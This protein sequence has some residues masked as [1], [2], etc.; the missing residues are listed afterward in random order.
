VLAY[1]KV[2][3]L[4]FVVEVTKLIEAVAGSTCGGICYGCSPDHPSGSE[5][6]TP[7]IQTPARL[8]AVKALP[9]AEGQHF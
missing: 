6:G 2:N 4:R 8:R 5:S 1:K 9:V 3:L 7:C